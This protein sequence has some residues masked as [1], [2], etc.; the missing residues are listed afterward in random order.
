MI[1]LRVW[2]VAL[3]V[4]RQLVIMEGVSHPKDHQVGA[5]A[6]CGSSTRWMRG[7]KVVGALNK[8][9]RSVTNWYKPYRVDKAF[10]SWNSN[11]QI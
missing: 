6:A 4:F 2:V 10:F 1:A 5:Y 8:P 11:S 9:N 7:C 3:E